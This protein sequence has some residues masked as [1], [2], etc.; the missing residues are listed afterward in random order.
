M[1]LLGHYNC[2]TGQ[3]QLLLDHLFNVARLGRKE[4]ES[5]NQGYVIY[6]LGLFHDLGK[7]DRNFQKKLLENPNMHVNHSS[8]GAKFIENF[9]IGCLDEYS[10]DQQEKLIE[11][12]EILMYVITAHHGIYDI[13]VKSRKNNKKINKLFERVDYDRNEA[14]IQY[15]YEQ[16]VIP[17]TKTLEVV[18]SQQESM[19]FNVLFH[20]AFQE[21]LGIQEKIKTDNR[22]ESSFYRGMLVRLYLSFLKNADIKDTINAFEEK[23]SERDNEKNKQLINTYLNSVEELY[24]SFGNPQTEMNRIR[25]KLANQIKVRGKQD[26]SGIFRLNLPT[27]SGKTLMSLRY[28][29]QQMVNQNKRQF[30]YIAPFLSIL[31]QNALAMKNIIGNEGVLEHHSNIFDEE[32]N[33]YDIEE[34]QISEIDEAKKDYLLDSWDSNAVLTTMV[35][36]FQTLFKGKSAN[37]R[38]FSR[39]AK[40]VIILDEVQSLPIE[41]TSLFNLSMNFLAKAMDATVVLCTATQ[42]KYDDESIPFEIDYGGNNRE[43][44]DLVTLT[45]EE[46]S[47]FDRVVVNKL[48]GNQISDLEHIVSEVQA[49]PDESILIILNTKKA[50]ENLYIKL[51]TNTNRECYYLSTNLCPYHRMEIIDQMRDQLNKIPIVCVS[52]QLIEAGV[53][54]DFNRLIRSYAGIDSLVQAMGRCNREGSMRDKGKVSLV[55]VSKEIENISMLKGYKNKRDITEQIIYSLDSPLN[56]TELNDQ[57]YE[58]YYANSHYNDFNYPLAK[59]MPTG[60]DLLSLNEEN[61]QNLDVNYL[62]QSFST[63]AKQIDLIANI[64][65]P[66]IVNYNNNQQLIEELI[67]ATRKYEF[68][69]VANLQKKLQVY[70]INIYSLEKY[71]EAI[72]K[73]P[74][75]NVLILAESNYDSKLGLREEANFMQF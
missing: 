48:N 51:T 9:I 69:K 62:S 5:I 44:V 24:L 2:E 46:R 72:I 63:A 45:K 29:C 33:T 50:A 73:T 43:D 36:F 31:E 68:E 3:K 64:T 38:R 16:D 52:T 12:C 6:L 11:F 20:L 35:Q 54:L 27:G 25:T 18:L 22:E 47:I 67:D 4:A 10:I 53:D 13:P 41:V 65:H 34:S 7:A 57:F 40:S 58:Y 26:G 56:I 21:F 1:E 60:F 39:L 17:F 42:P 32:L 59:D 61:C 49:H 66:V 70:T 23:I 8:A 19:T 14:S 37:I 75:E 30:F 28:A 15:A 74:N 55:R 71:K